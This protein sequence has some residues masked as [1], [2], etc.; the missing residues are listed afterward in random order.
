MA[1]VVPA[2]EAAVG[3]NWLPTLMLVLVSFLLC[4]WMSGQEEPK[5]SWFYPLRLVALILLLSWAL[6]R[7]HSC[8]PGDGA[9]LAVPAGLI[10]LAAYAV[11]KGSAIRA[12]SVLRYGMYF[13]LVLL[14]VLG[15]PQ[16]RQGNIRPKAELPDMEL[17]AVLLLPLLARKTGRYSYNPI[18]AA[19]LIASVV[20]GGCL[21]LY[22]YSRGVCIGEAVIHLESVAACAITV[23][24][25]A[26]LCFLLDGIRRGGRGWLVWFGALAAYGFYLLGIPIDPQ[27][28]VLLIIVLWAILPMLWKLKEKMKKRENNA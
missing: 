14:A 28:F 3:K 7:T 24:Y 8:W 22:Q 11:W 23:G 26:M 12:S 1:L 20:A 13:V 5:W 10:L 9:E 4:T 6:N 25:F 21:S 16:I 2:A 15:I 18:G 17:A 27:L 19:A